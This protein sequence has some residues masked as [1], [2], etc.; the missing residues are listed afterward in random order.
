MENTLMNQR[1]LSLVESA[2]LT[3]L[4]TLVHFRNEHKRDS[5][6]PDGTTHCARP[7][8]VALVPA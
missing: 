6:H 7:L 2:V 5:K 8:V 3:S 4:E 1:V